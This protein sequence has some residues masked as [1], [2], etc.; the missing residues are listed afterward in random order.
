MLLFAGTT[1]IGSLVIGTMAEQ[2]GVQAAVVGMATVCL[3][4]VLAAAYYAQRQRARLLPDGSVSVEA[5]A[6]TPP[7]PTRAA[8]D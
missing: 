4:G 1:P 5:A 8:A 2:F 6:A 7:A 3:A